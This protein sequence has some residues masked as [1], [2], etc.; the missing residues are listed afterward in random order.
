MRLQKPKLE[1]RGE[2]CRDIM[3]KP[4]N[5]ILCVNCIPFQIHVWKLWL[6]CDYLWRQ[7]P[8]RGDERSCGDSSCMKY[9]LWKHKDLSLGSEP[10]QWLTQCWGK[11]GRGERSE[12]GRALEVA[13]QLGN[14]FS[15]K[16]KTPRL[17]ALRNDIW[18]WSL[19]FAHICKHVHAIQTCTHMNR[20]GKRSLKFKRIPR[21]RM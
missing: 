17:T 7:G 19:V 21:V 2:Y 8:W 5:G 18:G 3:K 11:G 1:I 12:T 20:C 14:T 16:K 15:K 6:Q 9:S 10:T 4:W 13:G